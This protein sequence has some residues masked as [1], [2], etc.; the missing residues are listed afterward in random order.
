M[1]MLIDAAVSE[2]AAAPVAL[3]G[4][5]MAMVDCIPPIDDIE[6]IEDIEEDISIATVEGPVV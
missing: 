4:I 1:L 3:V 2:A 5:A 6:D